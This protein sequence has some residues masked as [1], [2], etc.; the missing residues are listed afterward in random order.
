V[1]PNAGGLLRAGTPRWPASSGRDPSTDPAPVS[2]SDI[3]LVTLADSGG[4]PSASST[5]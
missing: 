1:I 2:T 4:R 5:G 3:V